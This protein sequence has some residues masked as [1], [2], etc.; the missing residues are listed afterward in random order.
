VKYGSITD[1]ICQKRL[2]WHEPDPST[3]VAAKED[4]IAFD[5]NPV[6]PFKSPI[7]FTD[8]TDFKILRN[9]WPYGVTPGI[10]HLVVW[11]KTPIPVK[12]Q[13]GDVTDESRALIEDF[14]TKTF[15]QRLERDPRFAGKDA[16][17]HLLWFKNWTSLQ[18]VRSLEHFHL[19]LRDVPDDII[20]EWTGEE[21][22]V[23]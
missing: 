23:Q 15:A 21:R 11:T 18:S 3:T 10:G 17:S 16:Q 9:D 1:Y 12:P 19:M 22:V 13:N 5:S 2:R 4:G 8:V 7:P 20:T 6:I 14:V